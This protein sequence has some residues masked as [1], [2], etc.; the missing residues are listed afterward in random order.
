MQ[1][2]LVTRSLLDGGLSKRR[3]PTRDLRSGLG[4]PVYFRNCRFR[5]DYAAETS[6]STL[7]TNAPKLN[8]F[9]KNTEG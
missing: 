8:G 1:P 4:D 5:N 6:R 7:A 9:C 3:L 2:A